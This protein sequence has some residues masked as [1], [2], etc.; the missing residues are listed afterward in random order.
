MSSTSDDEL[1]FVF[2]F[3][4]QEQEEIEREVQEK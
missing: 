1:D 2:H 4:Y 3:K